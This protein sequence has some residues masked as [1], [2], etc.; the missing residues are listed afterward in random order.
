MNKTG[1]WEQTRHKHI[2]SFLPNAISVIS[3]GLHLNM[4]T[5]QREPSSLGLGWGWGW[6]GDRTPS[7]SLSFLSCKTD[8]ECRKGRGSHA[9][10]NRTPCKYVGLLVYEQLMQ[11]VPLHPESTT[12]RLQGPA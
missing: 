12:S 10:G 11:Q 9:V 5:Q 2:S 7:M 6:G 1:D 8:P 4:G 3:E